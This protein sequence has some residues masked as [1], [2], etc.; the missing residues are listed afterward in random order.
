MNQLQTGANP[1]A[2]AQQAFKLEVEY[3]WRNPGLYSQ[4]GAMPHYGM[5]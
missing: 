3:F 1:A 4:P 5:Q 2:A